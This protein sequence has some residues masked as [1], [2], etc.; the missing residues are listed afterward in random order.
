MVMLVSWLGFWTAQR[1]FDYKSD[2]NIWLDAVKK[3]PQNARAHNNLAT[4][5]LDRGLPDEGLEHLKAACHYKPDFSEAQAN[6]GWEL[7]KRGNV[8]EGKERLLKALSIKPDYELG[9]F[10]LGNVY[11]HEGDTAAAIKYFTITLKIN[12]NHEKAFFN[13][14]LAREKEGDFVEAIRI[15]RTLLQVNP[16]RVDALSQLAF[17]LVTHKDVNARNAN[18]ALP[19]AEK[20]VSMTKEE[21]PF[22][23]EALAA[24]FAELKRYPEAV[25]AA[26][27]A[28]ELAVNVADTATVERLEARLK[29][30][31]DSK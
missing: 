15:Y 12:P 18:E 10:L 24:V 8:E 11:L 26:Q 5:F 29:Q 25:T 20:A 14:G 31:R 6:L 30:Y 4:I 16:N 21:R 23:L 1:N 19:L 17:A 22:P 3:R 13:T 27:K 28:R 7:S 9:N 2:L